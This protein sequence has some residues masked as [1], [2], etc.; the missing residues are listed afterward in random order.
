[1][2]LNR[3]ADPRVRCMGAGLPA[4]I[5]RAQSGQVACSGARRQNKVLDEALNVN[6]PVAL[7]RNKLRSK[8]Q[9]KVL[10]KQAKQAVLLFCTQNEE[11]FTAYIK[12]T[13]AISMAKPSGEKIKSSKPKNK[14]ASVSAIKRQ[15]HVTSIQNYSNQPVR[16]NSDDVQDTQVAEPHLPNDESL[17]LTGASW[18]AIYDGLVAEIKLRKYSPKTLVSYRGWIR[19]FQTF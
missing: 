3:G 7:F 19:K 8:H 5:W 6:Q 10:C 1:M 12:E 2:G 14:F 15:D 16:N 17:K 13:P 9:S 4:D 11:T 18:V